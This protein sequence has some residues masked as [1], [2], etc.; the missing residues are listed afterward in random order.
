M[1]QSNW[2]SEPE[3]GFDFQKLTRSPSKLEVIQTLVINCEC[4]ITKTFLMCTF[5]IDL[6]CLLLPA[7]WGLFNTMSIGYY[8][9]RGIIHS[10]SHKIA[11]SLITTFKCVSLGNYSKWFKHHAEGNLVDYFQG[12]YIVNWWFVWDYPFSQILSQVPK[13]YTCAVGWCQLREW[14]KPVLAHFK[15]HASCFEN[16]SNVLLGHKLFLIIIVVSILFH[17]TWLIVLLF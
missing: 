17:T 9:C 7:L 12:E 1:V 13:C 11:Y 10:C 14:C 3:M 8:I 4:A 6:S 2:K 5:I 16:E 15:S